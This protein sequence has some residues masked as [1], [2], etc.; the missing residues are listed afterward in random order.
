MRLGLLN[1]YFAILTHLY[2]KLGA[3]IIFH[4][5]SSESELDSIQADSINQARISTLSSPSITHQTTI[6]TSLLGAGNFF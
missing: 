5:R 4:N 6:E 3:F 2:N 1:M